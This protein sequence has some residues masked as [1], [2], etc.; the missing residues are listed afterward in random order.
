MATPNP[1]KRTAETLPDD[2]VLSRSL[3]AGKGLYGKI[4]HF[5]EKNENILI[6][7]IFDR[8]PPRPIYYQNIT[9]PSMNRGQFRNFPDAIGA[10]KT[11]FPPIPAY[12]DSQIRRDSRCFDR[13][14]RRSAAPVA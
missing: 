14:L 12:R 8:I 1:R 9:I 5:V 7:Q 13:L 3:R 10:V 4:C 11:P 2:H 6:F